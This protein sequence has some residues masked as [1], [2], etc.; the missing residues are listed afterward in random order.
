M[1]GDSFLDYVLDQLSG[2]SGL[3]ARRMFGAHGL[4]RDGVFFAIVDDGRL[5]F[6]TDEP[7]REEYRRRGM[8][9][10]Q[11]TPKQTL[12]TYYEVPADVLEDDEALALWAE[13]AVR[14]ARES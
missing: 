6:K 2:L 9:P 12:K 10:F 3:E 13:G 7:T 4:Y 1:S 8:G 5:Y 11:P 14:V